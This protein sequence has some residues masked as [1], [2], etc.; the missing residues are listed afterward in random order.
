MGVVTRL[1][2][3]YD[4]LP[5]WLKVRLRSVLFLGWR[6]MEHRN[7]LD[8]VGRERFLRQAFEYL[9]FNGISGDYAEFG[10]Y[11]G[12]TFGAAYRYSRKVG[13]ETHLW[14]FDS[15]AGLPPGSHQADAHPAWRPGRFA[16]SEKDFHDVLHYYGVP[17]RSYTVIPGFYDTTLN[18]SREDLPRD[19]GLAY[20]DCDMYSSTM[21]VLKFL[22][23]RFKHGMLLA[24]DDYF[25]Y[26]ANSVSGEKRALEDCLTPDCGW[27]LTPFLPIGWHGLSF[28]V[29]K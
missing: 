19:I 16:M 9:A 25:C 26:S 17:R 14:S 20:I 18:L 13:R 22:V 28:I 5:W 15:F 3:T 2:E 6:L 29:E 10:S 7:Y 24:F 11:T 8:R 12:L 1:T 4:H 27:R 23:S 21:P